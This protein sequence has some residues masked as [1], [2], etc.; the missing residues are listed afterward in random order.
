MALSSELPLNV[1]LV[2][3][4][5][6]LR[7]LETVI[8]GLPS[9]IICRCKD[10]PSSVCVDFD[11]PVE[12]V[13]PGLE[14]APVF[15]VVVIEVAAVADL[16]SPTFSVDVGALVVDV[17]SEVGVSLSLLVTSSFPFFFFFFPFFD[18]DFDFFFDFPFLDLDFFLLF[19]PFFDFDFDLDFF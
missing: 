18:F 13:P 8:L 4:R 6:L 3:L 5:D 1:S 9:R 16:V 14:G 11:V 12:G 7:P 19:F 17:V 2:D 15:T 10:V